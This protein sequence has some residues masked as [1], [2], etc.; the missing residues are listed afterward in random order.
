MHPRG[1]EAREEK[2]L[3]T[4][5]K[6]QEMQEEL[7]GLKL[8][9]QGKKHRKSKRRIKSQVRSIEQSVSV[10]QEDDEEH[11][12]GSK[13]AFRHFMK[14]IRSHNPE[15][16]R[17]AGSRERIAPNRLKTEPGENPKAKEGSLRVLKKTKVLSELSQKYNFLP[18]KEFSPLSQPCFSPI[19]ELVHACQQRFHRESPLLTEGSPSKGLE[20]EHEKR[21]LLERLRSLEVKNK[22]NLIS[23]R[24]GEA[25]RDSAV[26]ERAESESKRFFKE[27]A[28]NRQ[29]NGE[30]SGYRLLKDALK[31]P[32]LKREAL[33]SEASPSSSAKR[34][35]VAAKNMPY[36]RKELRLKHSNER[37]R[38]FYKLNLM[39]ELTES[40]SS[41]GPTIN[42]IDMS[43]DY[44]RED[45][46]SQEWHL[47]RRLIKSR[48]GLEL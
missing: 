16:G 40:K 8:K 32:T 45:S 43:K 26:K 44:P 25:I 6:E 20:Y 2:G 3:F 14:N 39:A 36:Q 13:E 9:K 4:F 5:Y 19:S 18:P 34:L 11:R 48:L 15:G 42:L 35:A 37:R 23:S 28:S 30:W 21:R 10:I 24:E 27:V 12:E 33:Q 41:D 7:L 17:P 46:Y 47:K 22:S 29:E 31:L 38:E 1:E